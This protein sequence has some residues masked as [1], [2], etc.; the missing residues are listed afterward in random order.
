M[1]KI[2][3]MTNWKQFENNEVFTSAVRSQAYIVLLL[4]FLFIFLYLNFLKP[5]Y[6]KNVHHLVHF[7]Q[8][9]RTERQ[10]FW[11]IANLVNLIFVPQ[12]FGVLW[13]RTIPF[14]LKFPKDGSLEE[15][16]FIVSYT[17][18]IL[19][20]SEII[21]TY[22]YRLHW[23]YSPDKDSSLWIFVKFTENEN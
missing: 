3:S 7:Q 8:Q 10:T 1:K 18:V 9:C 22:N 17:S 2:K 14:S 4:F 16:Q 19:L 6:I 15:Y 23:R 13:C 11:I 5:V 20:G 12:V 21:S